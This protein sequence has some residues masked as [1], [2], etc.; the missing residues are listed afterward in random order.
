M[1]DTGGETDDDFEFLGPSL[2]ARNAEPLGL[3]DRDNLTYG[4]AVS[5]NLSRPDCS[6]LLRASNLVET[7]LNKNRQGNTLT[8]L[9]EK[10]TRKYF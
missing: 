8:S 6:N 2:I 1:R 4:N 3:L 9:S 7:P 5:S 10:Q